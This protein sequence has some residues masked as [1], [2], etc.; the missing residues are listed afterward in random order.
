M[1]L[2]VPAE[3]ITNASANGGYNES[4]FL[5]GSTTRPLC[6][7]DASEALLLA[8]ADVTEAMLDSDPYLARVVDDVS[9]SL[10]GAEA[11]TR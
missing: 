11:Q 6:T 3:A 9:P 7:Y 5:I 10:R 1:P 2:A 4:L 8:E